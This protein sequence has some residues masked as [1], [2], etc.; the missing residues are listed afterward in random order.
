D[1][2]LTRRAA[3][4]GGTAVHTHKSGI[5]ARRIERRRKLYRAPERGLAVGSRVGED[6]GLLE[7][8]LAE[9]R[10]VGLGESGDRRSVRRI[11]EVG[12]RR[13]IVCLEHV[14]EIFV[15]RRN[16]AATASACER[17]ASAAARS[18]RHAT[19]DGV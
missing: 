11:D 7:G 1:E 14:N 9:F 6:L 4:R 16:T 18:G 17:S 8:K 5:V 15:A 13:H 3:G 10:E 2:G 12:G 19:S